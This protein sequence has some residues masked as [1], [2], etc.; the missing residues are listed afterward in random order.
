MFQRVTYNICSHDMPP[1][2]GCT[3]VRTIVLLSIRKDKD[4]YIEKVI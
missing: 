2:L 3:Q 1:F 4:S